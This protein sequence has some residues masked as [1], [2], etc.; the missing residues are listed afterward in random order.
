MNTQ[1]LQQHTHAA[2]CAHARANRRVLIG[3]D[4]KGARLHLQSS[5]EHIFCCFVFVFF[6]TS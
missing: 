3:H 6:F 4:T 2:Q 1:D 5:G